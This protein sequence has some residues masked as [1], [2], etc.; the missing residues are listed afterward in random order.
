MLT[1]GGYSVLLGENMTNRF[2]FFYPQN[3]EINTFRLYGKCY[4]VWKTFW[5]SSK[6]DF[7]PSSDAVLVQNLQRGWKSKNGSSPITQQA[8]LPS[9]FIWL[10][11]FSCLINFKGLNYVKDFSTLFCEVLKRDF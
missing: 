3:K 8:Y 6:V 5:K 2:I 1:L 4:N 11:C 9:A 10:F 7:P